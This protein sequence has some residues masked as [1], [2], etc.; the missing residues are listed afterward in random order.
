MSGLNTFSTP[1]CGFTSS[2][3]TETD[4]LPF[5][6]ISMTSLAMASARRFFCCSDLPRQSFTIT[7]GIVSFP[8]SPFDRTRHNPDGRGARRFADHRVEVGAAPVLRAVRIV[9]TTKNRPFDRYKGDF[10]DGTCSRDSPR[11]LPNCGLV[12]T[13][14]LPVVSTHVE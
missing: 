10:L 13:R 8:C 1:S 12:P 9:D 3:A 11:F 14:L 6:R 4:S 7:C 5:C 2:I